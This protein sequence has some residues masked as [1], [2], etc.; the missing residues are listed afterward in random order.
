M[1]NSTS[2]HST[3]N[4]LQPGKL[5]FAGSQ[6]GQTLQS[7]RLVLSSSVTRARSCLGAQM[8]IGGDIVVMVRVSSSCL[9][10]RWRKDMVKETLRSMFG[11][12]LAHMVPAVIVQPLFHLIINN[13]ILSWH[14]LS[15]CGSRHL[16]V[17]ARG[18]GDYL[19]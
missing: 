15:Y 4:I 10:F 1:C 19:Y 12:P 6:L 13:L 7:S 18:P 14:G 5:C 2:Y 8:V 9:G 16:T 3:L 17:R 11:V